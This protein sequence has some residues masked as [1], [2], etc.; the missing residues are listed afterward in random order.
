MSSITRRKALLSG[1]A[2]AT[3]V[4]VQFGGVAG[5]LGT[6]PAQAAPG[7][8]ETTSVELGF[9]ALTDAA[10]LIVAQEKGFFAKQGMTGVELKKQ[11]SWAVTRDNLELGGARGGIDGAHILSPM[12]YLLTTGAISKSKKPV[13]MFI[14]ARLNTNGQA[15]SASNEFKKYNF[16]TKT[17]AIAKAVAEK[18]K[19]GDKFKAAVTFP[20]GNHDLWTRYWLAANGVDPNKQ[21]DLVVIP[22]PQMVANMQSGTMDIFCVGEPWNERLVNKKLGYTALITGQLWKDHPEKAFAMRADWV[23]KNP[24]ATLRLLMAVQ[25]AQKWADNPANTVELSKM[26]AKDKYVKANADDLLPRLQGTIDFGNGKVAKMKN[27]SMKF[28]A[29]NASFP[30]KSHDT[31]FITEDIRWGYL[32]KGT[33]IKA[34]VNKVNRSDLWRAAAKANG[35]GNGPAGDSRGVEVFFDGVKFDAN[36]PQA[37]LNGLKIKALK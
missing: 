20:G 11:T 6:S 26:L 14:L 32:P 34:L 15:I 1:L 12:P 7:K 35:Y 3:G 23:K 31:W 8:P 21:A 24:N 9:I 10:P 5:L 18:N 25:Q 30:Y 22:P 27:L 33:N 13:P 28:W 19:T 29:D 36:N 17:P 4:V 2:A 37:Y 16:G